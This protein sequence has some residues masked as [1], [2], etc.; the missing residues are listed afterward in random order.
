M[1]RRFLHKMPYIP[2]PKPDDRPLLSG[3]IEIT[4]V[5]TAKYIAAPVVN[6][7]VVP[8]VQYCLN[9]PRIMA[10]PHLVGGCGEIVVGL[11]GEIPS[12]GL[13]TALVLHGFDNSSHAIYTIFTGE[14]SRTFTQ[15]GLEWGSNGL[16][17]TPVYG[18]FATCGLDLAAGKLTTIKFG[19][20]V[21]NLGEQT[22]KNFQ[23][24]KNG[25]LL[26]NLMLT[27]L[28]GPGNLAAKITAIANKYK[29][30]DCA[31]CA[32]EIYNYAVRMGL[33]PVVVF[34]NSPG[35]TISVASSRASGG[36]IISETGIHFGIKI[37]E[38][39]FG[40][41]HTN[42]AV[43]DSWINSFTIINAKGGKIIQDESA[44]IQLMKHA[45][46]K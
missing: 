5:S 34:L 36:C 11:Y 44:L 41:I 8:T 12:G 25:Q 45:K 14:Y 28:N 20:A 27:P 42:G 29:V 4:A 19:G 1:C 33:K 30:G 22:L 40:N 6:K 13:S 31:P 7:V 38:T 35:A 37:G 39:V 32:L 24:S 26:N 17:G 46:G 2:P 3:L 23:S 16:T 43:F 9:S 21:S 10:V 15:R 18:T